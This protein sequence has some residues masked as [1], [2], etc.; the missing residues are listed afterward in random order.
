MMI[1]LMNNLKA[2]GSENKSYSFQNNQKGAELEEIY[3]YVFAIT[4][5]VFASAIVTD[6]SRI[7]TIICIPIILKLIDTLRFLEFKNIIYEKYLILLV[8][9]S[10]FIIQERW[11]YGVV[12]QS[13]PNQALESIYNFFARLVN[14]LMK[15]IWI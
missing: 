8:V 2:F 4:L 15:N 13:S 11:I 12:Y 14:S 5:A 3:R 7:F 10:N 6:V 9:L 1:F